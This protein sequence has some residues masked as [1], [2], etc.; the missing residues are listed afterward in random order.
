M[1]LFHKY[2]WRIYLETRR[3]L[4]F[5]PRRYATVDDL[6]ETPAWSELIIGYH[7]PSL[8]MRRILPALTH[9]NGRSPSASVRI[10]VWIFISF[11]SKC[12]P[13]HTSHNRLVFNLKKTHSFDPCSF[14]GTE[15]FRS[16]T[17]STCLQLTVAFRLLNS[18][19]TRYPTLL[20]STSKDTWDRI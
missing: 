13:S 3:W 2:S 14:V 12:H 15:L 7:R 8:G 10:W 5:W 16:R 19:W 20:V 17:I 6:G 11:H 9:S 4:W 1:L 18:Q